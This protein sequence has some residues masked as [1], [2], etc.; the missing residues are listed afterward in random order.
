MFVS[1]FAVALRQPAGATIGFDVD[2]FTDQ[3]NTELGAVI[4]CPY[5]SIEVNDPALE[6]KVIG[7]IEENTKA[8]TRQLAEAQS[9][10]SAAAERH[11]A[12]LRQLQEE[13]ET[14]KSGLKVGA[15]GIVRELEKERQSHSSLRD[16]EQNKARELDQRL[17]VIRLKQVE[18]ESKG[19]QHSAEREVFDRSAKQ[20]EQKRSEWEE[21]APLLYDEGGALRRKM[22]GELGG[23]RQEI[24]GVSLDG[25]ARLIEEALGVVNEEGEGLKN[26]LLEL[27]LSNRRLNGRRGVTFAPNH[28]LTPPISARRYG[29]IVGQAQAKLDQLRKQR[30]ESLRQVQDLPLD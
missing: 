23:L 24:S 21:E 16:A 11:I 15:D 30:E 13:L 28:A 5:Q 27:E 12:E 8:V 26:E 25:L 1:E 22:L 29:S 6:K 20:F 3:L 10:N 4:Q 7:A 14:L 9:R 19:S 18:L 17:R 2:E